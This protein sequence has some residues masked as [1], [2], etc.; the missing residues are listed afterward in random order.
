M[1]DAEWRRPT[2]TSP[3]RGASDAD[4]RLHEVRKAAKRARYAAEAAEP[5]LGPRARRMAR[6]AEAL[7]ELLGEHQD[8]V[9]ARSLLRQ[10]GVQ[11]HLAG[12][13]GYT[14]GMLCGME[15]LPGGA[16]SGLTTNRR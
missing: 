7:Q 8:S 10:L 12:E 3:E 6:R 16:G 1:P 9:T 5:V 4:A 14:Y 11:A 13:N 15:D 2:V